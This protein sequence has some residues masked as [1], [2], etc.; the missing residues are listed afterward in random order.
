MLD[1]L[2]L[3][4]THVELD[5]RGFIKVDEQYQTSTPSILAIGDVIGRVQL[6][7]VASGRRYG[8]SQTLV[9]TGG[10]PQG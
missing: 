7:P 3:E 6:T 1:N 10:V 9:Q 8:G 5:E 4:N 2:G